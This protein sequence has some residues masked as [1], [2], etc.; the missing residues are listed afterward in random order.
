MLRLVWQKLF[1]PVLQVFTTT[2]F[3]SFFPMFGTVDDK[4][5]R[6]G[7][8][9]LHIDSMSDVITWN[10]PRA[11]PLHYQAIAFQCFYDCRLTSALNSEMLF[12]LILSAPTG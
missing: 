1:F 10:A 7:T 3:F 12:M 8:K 6:G 11:R 5:P 4:P 9:K 2:R